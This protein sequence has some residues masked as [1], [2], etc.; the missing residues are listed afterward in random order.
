[1]EFSKNLSEMQVY[2]QDHIS[3]SFKKKTQEVCK[4]E[5]FFTELC[6]FFHSSSYFTQVSTNNVF[7]KFV[8]DWLA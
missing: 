8:L 5:I 4:A 3:W 1:M 6:W 2:E 7:F